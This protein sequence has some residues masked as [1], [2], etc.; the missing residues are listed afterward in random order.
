MNPSHSPL[1]IVSYAVDFGL[2]VLIWLVQL[3]V[4]PSFR[5]IEK[6]NFAAWHARYTNA[7]GFIAGPLMVAQLALALISLGLTK[8]VHSTSYVA[9]VAAT[10]VVTF[11]RFVPLHRAL[12]RSGKRS[13]T[14]ESL[15]R[16]NWLRVGLWSVIAL[17][18]LFAL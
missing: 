12:Q 15:L 8:S 13:E 9:L 6:T 14:I 1:F 18:L 2:C 17:R 3:V 11:S 10:W 4:Y 5:Y 7:Q 16:L